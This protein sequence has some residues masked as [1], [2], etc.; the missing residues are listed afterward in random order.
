MHRLV[1]IGKALLH[2]A[3]LFPPRLQVYSFAKAFQMQLLIFRCIGWFVFGSFNHII[4]KIAMIT[5][6]IT[7]LDFSGTNI[8]TCHVGFIRN[9]RLG[10]FVSR[11]NPRAKRGSNYCY[12]QISEHSRFKTSYF[13]SGVVFMDS[14]RCYCIQNSS[15]TCVFDIITEM[16]KFV[17]KNQFRS[18]QF[19]FL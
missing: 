4:I 3:P 11:A 18:I 1:S 13:L 19:E 6:T 5:T 7:V 10:C 8:N 16:Y 14:S 2:S 12:R 15:G 9:D 17:W